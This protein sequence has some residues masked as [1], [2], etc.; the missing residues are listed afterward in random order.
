M[1]LGIW[2]IVPGRAEADAPH[3][4]LASLANM[5]IDLAVDQ[6]ALDDELLIRFPEAEEPARRPERAPDLPLGKTG[7]VVALLGPG[8]DVTSPDEEDGS[9]VLQLRPNLGRRGGLLRC[10]FEF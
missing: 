2:A 3:A 9:I 6:L 10:T 5:T 8:L 4:Q 1:T 7:S